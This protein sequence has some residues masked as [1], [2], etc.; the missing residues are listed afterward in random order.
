[1]DFDDLDEAEVVDETEIVQPKNYYEVG[2]DDSVQE[3]QDVDDLAEP[4]LE[5][6]AKALAEER[7][8]RRQLERR[9]DVLSKKMSGMRLRVDE[10]PGLWALGSRTP[11]IHPTAF[12]A[13]GASVIGTV[14]MER[15][16]SVW[17]N[18]TLR[19]D[20][21]NITIGAGS[22][23]QDNSILHCDPGK[24]LSIG[25]NVLVGHQ[26]CLHGCTVG[27]NCL[28]GM[29]T[30]MLDES[31]VGNDC[32]VA[33]GSFIRE[34]IKFPD[35]CLIG[36][37]PAKKIADLDAQQ[38]ELVRSCASSYVENKERFLSDLKPY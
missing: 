8:Q 16:S 12:I 15:D 36:G 14:K 34:R 1:M 18:C 17:F 2:T 26:V 11:S 21:E 28:I 24:P 31:K 23:V 6:L 27:N 13:P 4:T 20:N 3:E 30:T 32:L 19:G 37:N 33:A 7:K 25:K 9:L 38:L 35:G 10:S 5:G 29:R 22:D